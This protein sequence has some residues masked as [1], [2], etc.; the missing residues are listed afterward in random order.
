MRFVRELDAA[1]GFAT[2]TQKNIT[3]KKDEAPGSSFVNHQALQA[4]LKILR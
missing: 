2:A 4:F 1:R 3:L